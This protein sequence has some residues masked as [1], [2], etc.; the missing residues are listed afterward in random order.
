MT[1]IAIRAEINYLCD[2]V[3]LKLLALHTLPSEGTFT[4]LSVAGMHGGM[5]LM[6][7]KVCKST[8]H[9]FWDLK[10]SI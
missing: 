8:T 10:Y 5:P 1:D 2:T 7:L 6:P 4:V 3:V 9:G